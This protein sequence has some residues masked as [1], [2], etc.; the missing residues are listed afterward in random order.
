MLEIGLGREFATVDL[1]PQATRAVINDAIAGLKNA[2]VHM[3]GSCIRRVDGRSGVMRSVGDFIDLFHDDYYK[4]IMKAIFTYSGDVV[5]MGCD[6]PLLMDPN[7]KKVFDY[8]NNTG[9]QFGTVYWLVSEKGASEAKRWI[10]ARNQCVR[11]I[12]Y[13]KELKDLAPFLSQFLA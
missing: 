1:K 12:R 11:I 2:I 13:G 6:L 8:I 4:Y 10:E 3:Y 7:M 5:M 9:N